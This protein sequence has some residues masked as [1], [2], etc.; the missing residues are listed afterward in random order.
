M[1]DS[2]GAKSS[3]SCE[4]QEQRERRK[5]VLLYANWTFSC[6]VRR[7]NF[8]WAASRRPDGR[9]AHAAG[10]VKPPSAHMPPD[11]WLAINTL[12]RTLRSGLLSPSRRGRALFHR[13]GRGAQSEIPYYLKYNFKNY[14]KKPSPSSKSPQNASECKK[15]SSK[16]KH[17]RLFFLK[18]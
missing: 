18:A 12:M 13:G 3:L 15:P 11:P 2:K 7:Y 10:M 16:G 1:D 9:C 4:E 6:S 17:S 14:K 5:T 8:P